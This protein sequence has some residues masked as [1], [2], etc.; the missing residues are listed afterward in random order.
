MAPTKSSRVN[1]KYKKRYRVGNW[2]AYERGL[3]ARGDVTVWF[4]EDALSTWTPPPTRCRGGQQRYSNLAILTALTLR[5]LFHLPLRQTEGFVASLLRL[6][7][8]DLHAPDHTTLSR[9]NGD[10]LVPA[11]SRAHD[12]PIHLI[13]DSTGLKIY[14]AGEWCSRKHRKAHERGGWRKLHIGVD[15]DGYVV[16]EALTQ[17]TVDTVPDLLGQ[18]DAPL[19]RFTGDGAYDTRSVYTA[20]GAAGGPGVEVVVPPRRPATPSPEATGPWAQRIRHIER[21][22]EIGRQAWQKEAGYRQQARV[23]GTFL[24]Y[25]RILGGSLRAKGFEAQQR[26]AMVGCTVLNTMLALGTAQSSAVTA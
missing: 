8:L 25:K 12:G 17:N 13:V 2:P 3:R 4:T 6:M 5:M 26:E 7:G 19:R 16:A 15:D 23:E 24:R 9:R 22:A 11:L 21:I 20:V 14:G 1:P 10:V 18:I